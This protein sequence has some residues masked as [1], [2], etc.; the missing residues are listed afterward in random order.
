ML[1]RIRLV[2]FK[3]FVDE[4][5]ELAPLTLLVGA[6]ASGKSNLLDAL[7]FLKGLAF[8]LMLSEVLNGETR[9][10]PD[11]W[12]GL[13]GRA[14]EAA[15]VGTTSFTID[16]EWLVREP[17][18]DGEGDTALSEAP[19]IKI[20][21]SVTCSVF[22]Q[23]ALDYEHFESQA[24]ESERTRSGGSRSL[25][26]GN[27]RRPDDLLSPVLSEAMRKMHFLE[28]DPSEMRDYGRRRE[29]L[30]EGGRNISGVLADLCDDPQARQSLVRWLV[31]LCAP[32]IEDID[33]LEVKE[34]GDV[35]SIFVEKGGK[36]I[37][38]RSI[39]DGTLHF[40]GTLLALRTAEPG[41]V[42]LIEEIEA[43]LHPT[44]IRL[45]VEYLEAV[46]RKRDI[47]IIATTHSPVVLQWLSD[48]TLRNTVV[49]GRVPDHEGT[50][51][52]RLGEL[53]HFS[54][55]LQHTS[56]D[57]MFTTGWLEMALG[58]CW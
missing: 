45:L 16:S 56:I 49:F 26:F 4:Q 32:E 57:E 23:I 14:E 2:D 18:I 54:E 3:S 46:T 11:A 1:K 36:R 25:L 52:R 42:L 51:M 28:I 30:G 17:A 31:E 21:H 39:S 10:R 48:E 7:R 24:L 37:S 55:V 12:P 15:R 5:V 44:R 41:S 19:R 6:N 29:P 53:P 35:M 43:D 38:A 13:R 22:P 40:L 58:R 8:D 34:L 27:A 47:Q 33:F 9:S 50:I 20:Q